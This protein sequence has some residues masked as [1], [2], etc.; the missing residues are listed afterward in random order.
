MTDA[1]RFEALNRAEIQRDNAEYLVRE[2]SGKGTSAR[3]ARA[4]EELQAVAA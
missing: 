4:I 3:Q 2:A 1:Q